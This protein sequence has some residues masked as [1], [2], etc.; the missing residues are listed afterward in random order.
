VLPSSCP[1]SMVGQV[2]EAAASRGRGAPASVVPRGVL[3]AGPPGVGKTFA[4]RRVAEALR[5]R[6]KV[7]G[8]VANMIRAFDWR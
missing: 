4:V 6:V 5:G 1:Y 8:G 7:G 2:I 3:L